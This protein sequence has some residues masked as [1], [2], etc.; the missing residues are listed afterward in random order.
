M[1][2]N[3]GFT[4]IEL[5]VTIA[6]LAIIATMAAP[7]FSENITKQNLD[8]SAR[9]ILLAL[10]EGRSKA[11]ALRSVI[12][13]CPSKDDAGI[14]ITPKQC[15]TKTISGADGDKFVDQNR[16]ILANISEKVT[17]TSAVSG[18]V[19]LPIGS[20]QSTRTFTL[21]AA[22]TSKSINVAPTGASEITT[23]TC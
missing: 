7:S 12:V 9:E 18:V 1:R 13:V 19:F 3:Q 8:N 10:N 21:C 11:V 5:M 20:V 2:N 22:K 4:L 16:V 23:G 6:V 14:K 17:V 15:V